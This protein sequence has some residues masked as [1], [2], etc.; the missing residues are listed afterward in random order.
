MTA[1]L[2]AKLFPAIKVR[3]GNL[4]QSLSLPMLTLLPVLKLPPLNMV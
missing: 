4:G 2:N 1:C 3:A